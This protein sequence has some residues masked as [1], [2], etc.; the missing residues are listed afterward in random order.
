MNKK[1]E[2]TGETKYIS[3]VR[4]KR[5]RALQNVRPGVPKGTVG[6]WIEE[7]RHLSVSGSA[8]VYGSAW[9]SGSARVYGDASVYGSAWETSPL[10]IKGSADPITVCSATQIQIGCHRHDTQWWIDNYEAIGAR[11]GYTPSQIE[12]YGMLIRVAAEWQRGVFE[13]WQ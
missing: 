8:W 9:V 7:E 1:Y 12:E 4:L 13:E 11:E 5:I 2:F 6:G 10:F 3:G